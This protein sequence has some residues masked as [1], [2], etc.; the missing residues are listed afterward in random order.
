LYG[1]ITWSICIGLA[2]LLGVIFQCIPTSD[3]WDLNPAH[4]RCLTEHVITSLTYFVSA[5]NVACDWTLGIFPF[6]IVKD[7]AIPFHQKA[8]VATI[9]A[10]GALASTACLVRMF[11]IPT[12]AET[13]KG[14]D[15]DFLCKRCF[16]HGSEGHMLPA[17]HAIDLTLPD[18]DET[19]DVAM[20]T[21]VESGVAITMMC[22]ATLRPLVNKAFGLSSSYSGCKHRSQSFSPYTSADGPPT[23]PQFGSLRQARA[24]AMAIIDADDDHMEPLR[25]E[26]GFS[27]F[28]MT[29][30]V[31]A[32]VREVEHEDL[33]MGSSSTWSSYKSQDRVP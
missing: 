32:R 19:T 4:K 1:L 12:L 23:N 30:A 31:N 26:V 6:F 3:W 5:L 28:N 22:V 24:N 11:Y 25:N 9:L 7:L 27:T 17:N 14:W 21:T 33:E 13:Y 20:W 15:G 8:L 18:P 29:K 10:V 2:F 16:E